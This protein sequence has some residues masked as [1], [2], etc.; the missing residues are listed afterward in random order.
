MKEEFNQTR[1]N[2]V[3]SSVLGALL[4]SIPAIGYSQT[5]FLPRDRY[6]AIPLDQVRELVGNSHF[7]LEWIKELV[8]ARPELARASWDW[9][10]GDW[11]SAID[12]ASHVGRKDIADY[13]ISKGAMPTIFTFAMLGDYDTVKGMITAY[14]G[15]QKNYGPHGITLLQHVKNGIE[16]GAADKEKAN[17]LVEYLQTLGDADG[18]VYLNLNDEEKVLY[19][20]DYKYGEGIDD[21]FTINLNNRKLLSLGSLGK[22]GGTLLCTAP[23]EFVYQGAWSVNVR[24]ELTGNVVTK[25][26]LTEPGLVLAARKL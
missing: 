17:Q 14:P 1:R 13:L 6:P 26:I 3:K 5:S 18:Q 25:L 19:L 12:A 21:R 16:A 22:S 7:N 20:G 8:N 11:E 9:G 23:H 4:A 10:F 2:L 24:F 15:I